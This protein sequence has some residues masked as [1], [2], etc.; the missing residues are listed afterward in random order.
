LSFP[1][2]CSGVMMIH[3]GSRNRLTAEA[4][5]FSATTI[6][7]MNESF[8]PDDFENIRGFSVEGQPPGDKKITYA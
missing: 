6:F 3:S 8:G 7:M 2:S 5:I 1:S 4:E